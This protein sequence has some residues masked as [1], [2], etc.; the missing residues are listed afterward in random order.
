MSFRKYKVM[1]EENV[2]VN[3]EVTQAKLHEGFITSTIMRI[4][5]EIHGL[6]P[7]TAQKLSWKKREE[8]KCMQILVLKSMNV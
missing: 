1:Q 4:L 3:E 6:S 8:H 2:P 5:H 7:H